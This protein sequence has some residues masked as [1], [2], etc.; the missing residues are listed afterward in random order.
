MKILYMWFPFKRTVG[1][2]ALMGVLAGCGFLSG[3]EAEP[4][5]TAPITRELIPT[6][7]PTPLLPTDIPLPPTATPEPPTPL[8]AVA[9]PTPLPA[10][11]E[12]T[13]LPTDTPAPAT[14]RLTVTGGTINV[15]RGPGTTFGV[16]GSVDN[17]MSFDVL[18]KN[19]AGDW[20]LFCCVNGEQGWVYGS[21]VQVENPQLVT[22]SQSIPAAPPTNTPAPVVAAPPPPTNTP[23]PAPAPQQPPPSADACAGIGGDGCKFKRTGG[24]SFAGNGGWNSSCKLCLFTAGC[25]ADSHKAAISS[26]WRKTDSVWLCQI[27]FAV[28]RCSAIKAH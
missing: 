10:A 8:P 3:A 9:E 11:A 1:L 23:V 26:G 15:R 28:W 2:L 27:R 24:P 18:G 5:P 21:L 7:T 4:T 25:M 17:G 14:A 19:P 13:P 12:P 20:Y 22:I 6:W 16:V